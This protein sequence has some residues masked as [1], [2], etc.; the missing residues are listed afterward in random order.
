MHK[1]KGFADDL[2]VISKDVKSHQQ[3]LSPHVLK[4]T[5]S[6]PTSKVYLP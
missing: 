2:T 6:F 5:D 4:A 3:A 1:A